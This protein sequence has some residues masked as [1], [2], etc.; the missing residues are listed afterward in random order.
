[1]STNDGNGIS[2]S[3]LPEEDQQHFRLLELPPELLRMLTSDTSTTLQF[4]SQDGLPGH[5]GTNA[6]VC[7]DANTFNLR[8]VNTSNSVYITQPDGGE[9]EDG[10]SSTGGLQAVA[11]SDSTLEL[12]P[13]PSHVNNAKSQIR[14]LL[15]TTYSSTGHRQTNNLRTK[16]ALF[17]D[18]PFSEMECAAAFEYMACFELDDPAGCF[19]PSGRVRLQAWKAIMEEAAV[20][21]LDLT[22]PLSVTQAVLII[23]QATDLPYALLKA[24][25]N[26]IADTAYSGKQETAIL[27]EQCVVFVGL[28]QLEASSQN[29]GA[30]SKTKF[31]AAWADLLPEKWRSKASLELLKNQYVLTNE[32]RD[33]AF[34]GGGADVRGAPS[35]AVPATGSKRKWHDKF[36]ASKKAT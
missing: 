8:Q 14:A 5:L 3:I 31:M 20:H 29:G 27:D 16:R 21:S 23:P 18:V 7:T 24:V 10:A 36:R 22:K 35:T 30:T 26:A 15:P 4:K 9:A 34:A 25:K 19:V 2:F 6:V 33:I 11:E 12:I 13:V 1:M 32:G 17:A 28:S